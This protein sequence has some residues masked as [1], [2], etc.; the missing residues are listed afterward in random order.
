MNLKMQTAV[1][2][3]LVISLVGCSGPAPMT[4]PLVSPVSTTTFQSPAA[5]PTTAVIPF[6]LDTPV[7]VGTSSVTGSGFPGVPIVILDITFMGGV[8]GTGKVD[9]NG[10]FSI[11]VSPLESGHIIGLALGE[12]TGTQWKAEDFAGTEYRGKGAT[13]IPQVGFFYDTAAVSQK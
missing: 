6:Q 8:L 7:V 11:N 13:Q 12:L 1:V 10:K 5:K 4:S 2:A 3:I 9:A